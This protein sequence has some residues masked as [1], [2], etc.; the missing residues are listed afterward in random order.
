MVY[1]NHLKQNLP[2]II[3]KKI[4]LLTQVGSSNKLQNKCPVFDRLQLNRLEAFLPQYNRGP[5]NQDRKSAPSFHIQY[6]QKFITHLLKL[7]K[8]CRKSRIRPKTNQQIDKYIPGKDTCG[9]KRD[10]KG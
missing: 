6:L 1:Y 7:T 10:K 8:S 4:T 3:L 5:L 2:K 9:P